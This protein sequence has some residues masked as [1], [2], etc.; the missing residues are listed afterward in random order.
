MRGVA[1]R[2]RASQTS[3]MMH[4]VGRLCQNSTHWARHNS[5]M[6]RTMCR[7]LGHKRPTIDADHLHS[8]RPASKAWWHMMTYLMCQFNFWWNCE[9]NCVTFHMN[10]LVGLIK[11]M[12]IAGKPV[13][14]RIRIRL[15]MRD[16]CCL[17]WYTALRQKD[18][19]TSK[20]SNRC[21]RNF[22]NKDKTISRRLSVSSWSRYH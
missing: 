12:L 21:I 11:P 15:K 7:V 8:T 1:T 13:Y 4:M 17:Q 19:P 6:S 14:L 3:G 18:K 22:H 20:F 16:L 5:I 2:K 9:H 10:T